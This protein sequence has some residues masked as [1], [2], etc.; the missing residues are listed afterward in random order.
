MPTRL[1]TLPVLTI[2][3]PPFLS[4]TGISYLRLSS[5]PST[6]I[7]NARRYCSSVASVIGPRISTPALLNAMS[8]RPNA[9][10]VCSTSDL[11]SASFAT[12]ARTNRPSPPDALICLT[13]SFPSSTRR[14]ETTTFA[15]AFAN[16]TPVHRPIPLVPPV[17][18]TTLPL[19]EDMG[20]PSNRDD[21][22]AR[23]RVARDLSNPS[24]RGTLA[25]VVRPGQMEPA[26]VA[27]NPGE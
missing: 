5:T 21:E 26:E 10:T 2:E 17:T 8:S 3:P 19:N 27:G 25:R 9:P 7:S 23:H 20:T 12:S 13:V 24:D 15:P 4:I 16:A 18:N 11:T 6:L 1:A 14:P 22:A